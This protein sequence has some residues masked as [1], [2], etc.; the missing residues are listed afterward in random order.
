MRSLK[1]VKRPLPLGDEPGSVRVIDLV[2]IEEPVGDARDPGG[3][4]KRERQADGAGSESRRV[5]P[6]RTDRL[7]SRRDRGSRAASCGALTERRAR[8]R[9]PAEAASMVPVQ[10]SSQP[11]C[12]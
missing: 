11:R 2:V 8:R 7:R 1:I 6:D 5:T 3:G 9:P 4:T 12:R 10:R